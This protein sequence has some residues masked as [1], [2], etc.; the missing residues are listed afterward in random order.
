VSTGLPQ[1]LA[2]LV[3][4]LVVSR[5]VL[6]IGSLQLLLL[7][8]ALVATHDEALIDLADSVLRLEDGRVQA[9]GPATGTPSPPR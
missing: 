8:T 4:S 9:G 3:S 5:S 2:A 7:A 1:V 6:L